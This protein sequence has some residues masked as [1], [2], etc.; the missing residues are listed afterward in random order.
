LEILGQ[1]AFGEPTIGAGHGILPEEDANMVTHSDRHM[2]LKLEILTDG[3]IVTAFD[4]ID[5][6]WFAGGFIVGPA[7]SEC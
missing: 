7:L 4:G 1:A 3:H 6:V 5:P 2:E